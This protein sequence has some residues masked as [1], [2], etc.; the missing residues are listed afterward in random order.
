MTLSSVLTKFRSCEG[1]LI[2]IKE[3][4]KNF[5]ESI[6]QK[7]ENDPGLL[8]LN[9]LNDIDYCGLSGVSATLPVSRNLT[10]KR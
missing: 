6:R 2:K 3:K 8:D 4:E 5:C 1:K 9:D 10:I 7:I